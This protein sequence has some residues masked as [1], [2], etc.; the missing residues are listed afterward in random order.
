M[1][2]FYSI[3][4][5]LL[6]WLIINHSDG[7]PRRCFTIGSEFHLSSLNIENSFLT[8]S[9]TNEDEFGVFDEDNGYE[10]RVRRLSDGVMIDKWFSSGRE[11]FVLLTNRYYSTGYRNA[12]LWLSSNKIDEENVVICFFFKKKDY[13]KIVY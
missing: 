1:I 5:I 6:F 7:L 12:I 9:F 11:Y 2:S 10:L 13:L 4:L 3:C 8:N